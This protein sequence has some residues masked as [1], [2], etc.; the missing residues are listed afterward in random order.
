LHEMALSLS[1]LSGRKNILW[2]SGGST[3][4]L[5]SD[6]APL[7]YSDDWRALYDELD[8]E[9]IAIYPIDA[10]GLT[11]SF[12][13]G[14]TSQHL[15]MNDVAQAT[16]GQALYNNNGLKEAAEHFLN[17][18]TSFYTLTYSPQDL[19][20]DNNWHKLRV[21]VDGGSYHL[22]YRSGYFADGR[23]RNGEQPHKVRTRLLANGEKLEV[24][25]LRDQPIIFQARVLPSS[26]P[27]LAGIGPPLLS[28]PPVLQKKRSLPFSIRYTVPLNAMT[29][30]RVDG[31]DQIVLGVASLVLNRDGR[32]VAQQAEQV[33]MV[34]KES[35]LQRKSN[36]PI[37]LDQ[38]LNLTK[39]DQFLN[40]GVWDFASGRFGILEVP[41][42]VHKPE[43]GVHQ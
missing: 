36:L 41:L 7:Q 32:P 5:V 29:V 19:K 43:K 35:S 24:S 39:D 38:Q 6:A 2:F 23:M 40:L 28:L 13:L 16:G 14:K 21:V 3:V 1:Q 8:Q 15:A 4:Y 30:S 42:E 27:S 11:T 25:E 33:K 12:G 34:L 37:T 10:R 22:G 18:D 31:K 9:R 17:T 20:F 26:D